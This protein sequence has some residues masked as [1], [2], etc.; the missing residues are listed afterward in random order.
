MQQTIT[1]ND[2]L[3]KNASQYA[4]TDDFNEIINIA[5]HELIKKHQVYGKRRQPP[6]SIAGKGKII[7][8]LIAPCVDI[9]DFECLK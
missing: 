1:V 8:D 5:L 9:G 7:G 6:L 4:G 2:T 3:L